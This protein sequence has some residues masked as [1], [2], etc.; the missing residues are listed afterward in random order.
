MAHPPDDF[1]VVV[2]QPDDDSLPRASPP[3]SSDPE[4]RPRPGPGEADVDER[5]IVPPANR[6]AYM[7]VLRT[8]WFHLKSDEYLVSPPKVWGG[9]PK[10]NIP[11]TASKKISGVEAPST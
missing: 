4:L 3:P 8:N 11:K 1:A 2:Y 10:D 5:R 7:E 9:K 6:K